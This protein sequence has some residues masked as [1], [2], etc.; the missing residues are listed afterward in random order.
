[1]E[2]LNDPSANAPYWL[3]NSD[4]NSVIFFNLSLILKPGEEIVIS[5]RSWQRQAG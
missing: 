2:I 4:T 3:Y 1:P 5:Y